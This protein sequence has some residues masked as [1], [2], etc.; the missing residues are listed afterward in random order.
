MLELKGISKTF[1]PGSLFEKKALVNIHLSVEEGEFISIIGA[2]GAGKSTLFNAISGSFLT[3]EGSP[4]F[5][6]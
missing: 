4:A 2:N 1:N 5:P 6:D 3:D